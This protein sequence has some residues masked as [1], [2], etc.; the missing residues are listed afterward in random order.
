[1]DPHPG[2]SCCE[3]T[4]AEHN[5]FEPHLKC[6]HSHCRN[7]D[8]QQTAH[9]VAASSPS[10]DIPRK[11]S[12]LSFGAIEVDQRGYARDFALAKKA[13]EVRSVIEWTEIAL[14]SHLDVDPSSIPQLVAV[15]H[16]A[17]NQI[18]VD[19]SECNNGSH[20]NFLF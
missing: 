3:F 18:M 14:L 17:H 11:K 19:L 5:P 10:D 6:H 15:T 2:G 20:Q 1:M 12:G 7:E 16:L 13:T 8:Q 9:I 4:Y